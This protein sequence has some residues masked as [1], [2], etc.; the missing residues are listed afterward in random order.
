MCVLPLLPH[1]TTSVR[2]T[3]DYPTKRERKNPSPLYP[4][5]L[6]VLL[7]VYLSTL[8]LCYPL[9]PLSFLAQ[10]CHDTQ[11]LITPFSLSSSCIAATAFILRLEQSPLVNW[12]NKLTI[13]SA[14]FDCTNSS[15][16]GDYRRSSIYLSAPRTD[17]PI[18]QF[19]IGLGLAS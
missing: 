13:L 15:Y 18:F 14:A 11:H 16:A 12:S 3:H 7:P 17:D 5:F 8:S 4:P 19:I 6:T 9:R 10:R 1:T 2:A